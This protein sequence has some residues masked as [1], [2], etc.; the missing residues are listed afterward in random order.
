[1]NCAE[2][3]RNLFNVAQHLPSP[4]K[5][6]S[7]PLLGVLQWCVF[8]GVFVLFMAVWLHTIILLYHSPVNSLHFQAN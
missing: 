2:T 1:M 8:S 3:Y 5:H 4:F 7:F 6:H